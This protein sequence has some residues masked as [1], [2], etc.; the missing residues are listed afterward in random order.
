MLGL[1][2]DFPLTIEAILRRSERMFS[3]K[4][5]ST[6]T[7]T[8]QE[9]ITFAELA[10]RARQIGG[11]LDNLGVSADGRVGSFGW[12]TANHTALY[13]GV[14]ATGRVLHTLNIR[15]FPEQLI[16]TVEH[17]QDELIFVDRS[18]LAL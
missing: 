2:Q 6:Q 12:N 4:V 8:G 5:I 3:S 13:F 10:K 11:V 14:P 15:L 9:R 17:A 1:M 18:L 7:V 16:Y